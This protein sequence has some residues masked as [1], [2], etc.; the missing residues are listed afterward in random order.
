MKKLFIAGGKFADIP[1]ILAAKKMGFFVITSGNNPNDL[2]H[3]YANEVHL[4]D[5]SNKETMRKLIEKLEIDVLIPACDDYSIL[6]CSYVNDYLKISNFDSYE[7]TKI[8]HHKDLWRAF[9][10]KNNID[11]PKA[12]GSS[13]LRES[14]RNIKANFKNEKI[15]IKPVDSAA[16][17]GVSAI[18]ADSANLE[19]A[20][21]Y[22]FSESKSKKIVI[23]EFIDG[24]K[25]GFST[26]LVDKK[27]RFYFYDNEQYDYNPFAVSGT[28]TSNSITLKMQK[29]I[30]NDIEKIAQILDL[31]DGIFH[32]QTIAKT[33][34][35][36]EKK[37]VIIESCRRAGGDL[38]PK[39]V[40]LASGVDYPK[41]FISSIAGISLPKYSL[42]GKEFFARQ[43]IMSH[44][45]GILESIE[46]K[47]EIKDNII[48]KCMWYKKG[49][50]ISDTRKYKAGIMFLEF[51]SNDEME[52][53]ISNLSNLIKI[54]VK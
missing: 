23:E 44:K 9:C 54:N 7:T 6:T 25:H 49:D 3:K 2:G 27:V 30:I 21:K 45:S 4:E 38:Y 32:T 53:K 43:C 29:N 24:T 10:Q 42:K 22:A 20:L 41:L 50:I 40:H 48:D 33:L 26:I 17:K 15:I 12:F 8:I 39:F 19:S 14:L 16:G 5:Y 18:N 37:L 47:P 28:T 51:S 13:N 1:T 52:E 36:G 34:N 46:I 11:S 35:S 31:K